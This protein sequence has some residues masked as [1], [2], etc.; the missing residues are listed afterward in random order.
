MRKSIASAAP[1]GGA[2]RYVDP[3][4]VLGT[5][6]AKRVA[7]LGDGRRFVGAGGWA[8]ALAW[9][10]DFVVVLFGV[11]T[12]IVALALVDRQVDFGNGMWLLASTG[13]VFGVPLV[14]GLFYGNGRALGAVLTGTQLVRLKDGGRLGFWAPWAMLVR[15]LLLPLLIVAVLAS[16]FAGGGGSP[17]GSPLRGSLDVDATRRLWA[18]EAAA[19][20]VIG[21]SW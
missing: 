13:L 16:S 5:E 18:A 15:T 11:G 12:G 2:A 21:P 8:L 3:V 9:M 10:V 6:V 20:S 14:Y 1:V 4:S 7:P 19:G 17:P